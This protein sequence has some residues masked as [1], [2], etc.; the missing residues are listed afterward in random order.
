MQERI[1]EIIIIIIIIKSIAIAI[2][3]SKCVSV[4][5]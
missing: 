1:Y 4:N 3:N 2:K 5:K